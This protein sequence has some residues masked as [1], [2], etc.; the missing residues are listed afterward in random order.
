MSPIDSDTT[1]NLRPEKWLTSLEVVIKKFK[2]LIEVNYS[3]DLLLVT[4]Y[5]LNTYWQ[6]FANSLDMTLV[7]S[8]NTFTV[9]VVAAAIMATCRLR[10]TASDLL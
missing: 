4:G 1:T 3:Y 8:C 10:S 2:L 5:V 7:L 6:S 9:S